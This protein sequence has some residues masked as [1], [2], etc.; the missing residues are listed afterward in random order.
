MRECSGFLP[1]AV[2]GTLLDVTLQ[3]PLKVATP[4]PL[5]VVVHG[6]GGSKAS[7]GD[8]VQPLL[9][10]GYAILRYSTRGFGNSWGQVNLVDIHAEI[11]DLRSMIGH[12]IDWGL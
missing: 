12:V 10:D 4:V 11:A 1:S 8:V 6:Y 2:D 9:D 7:S 3:I 5:V